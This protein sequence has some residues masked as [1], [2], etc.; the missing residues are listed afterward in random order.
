S[1]SFNIS[2]SVAAPFTCGS[3]KTRI[4]DVQGNGATSPLVG[5]IVDVEGIVVGSFQGTS[6]LRGFYLQEPDD[7]WDADP[8]TSEG[9]FIFESVAGPTVNIGDRVRVRGTVSEFTSSGSFLGNTQ[10]S[11]LT[12]IGSL[13]A[14]TICSTGNSFTRSTITLPIFNSAD[15]EKFEGMAV[16]FTQQLKVTGNFSLGTQGW[17]DLAP[18]VLFTPT[19]LSANPSTWPVQTDLNQRSVIALDDDSTLTNTNLFPTLF[20]QGGLSDSNTLRVGDLANYDSTSQTNTPL[21]GV[22]DDR[23]GE[24]RLQPTA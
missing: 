11:P 19:A 10:T 16:Q 24:Y 21:V 20:P 5:H 14:E 18:S 17:V 3:P 12:E 8:N 9:I 4:H 7:G 1:G 6:K 22:L 2:L 15:W 23:F 13:T